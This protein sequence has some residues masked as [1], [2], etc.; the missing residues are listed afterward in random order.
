LG[1]SFFLTYFLGYYFF[2]YSAGFEAPF[3]AA[4]G[5]GA[6]PPILVTPLAINLLISFPFNDSISLLRSASETLAP[7]EPKTFLIS[8]A[9]N[10]KMNYY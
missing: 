10:D 4:T 9:A 3:P 5:P 7:V 2:F 8:A 1:Y 6:D